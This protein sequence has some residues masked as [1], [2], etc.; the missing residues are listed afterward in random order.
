MF[1]LIQ[2]NK[3]ELLSA[4]LA[5]QI[6]T[7]LAGQSPL[8]SEHILVQSP[9]M[10]TW[11]RLEIA[12]HNGIAAG[13]EFP[14]PS[15]FIWQLC[16]TL[17]LDVPQE[18]AFTKEAMTWKLL[19]LLPTLI[20]QPIYA[21]LARYLHQASSQPELKR[22]QLAARI[23]DI[24]DQYLVYRPDWIADWEAE[25]QPINLSDDQA[26]QPQLWRELV[27]YNHSL[28]LSHYHRA[29]LHQALVD[30]LQDDSKPLPQLPA[31]LFVF[32]IS[33][34]PPQTLSVLHAL[35]HR[36][37]VTVLSLSP[38]QHYWGD[39]VNPKAR[40][41][42]NLTYGEK[43]QLPENWQENLIVGNPLL[44]NNGKLGREL[45]DLM[46]ELP[47]DAIELGD[48]L[49]YPAGDD[50]LL[51]G[52]QQDILDMETRGR[53]LGPDSE[54]YLSLDG[55]RILADD[56]D[57]LLLRSCHSPLREVE[58]LHDH[59]QFMLANNPQLS[60][61]DIVVMLPDVAAYAP[62]IDAVF[63]RR[64]GRFNIPYAIAD[65]GAS[66]ES[67]LINGFL[68][69]LNINRSRF[70]LTEV[71]AILEVPATL[72]RFGLDDEELAL[73][74]Q[75]L[76][77]AGI[78][79][80][81]SGKSRTQQQLPA[82]EQNSW[83]V[84]LKR[85]ILGY[86][87]EDDADLY[88]NH[89]AVAGVEG[90][91]A[92]ALGKLFNFIESLD[93]LS[94]QLNQPVDVA[95][96]IQQL[97]AI[98]DS[99]YSSSDDRD[100]QALMTINAAI[101]KLESELFKAG[102]DEPLDNSI[103]QQWFSS[104]LDESRV[105]QRYLAGSVNF[106]TLMP[107]RS[108]PF[109][110]VCLLGMND[111]LYPRV[112]HPIGF[113]L[114]A[115]QPPRKGDRSRRLD[116]RYLFLEALL[117]ARQQLYISY[118][119]RSQRDN[120]PRNPSM[121]IAE[122]LEYCQLTCMPASLATQFVAEPLTADQL[123]RLEQTLN[124]RLIK[125]QPL[126]PFDAS[127]YQAELLQQHGDLPLTPSFSSQWCPTPIESITAFADGTPLIAEQ[128][129]TQE[130]MAELQ[131]IE[132][133]ALVRF[134]RN[135]AQYFFNRSL[136]L[137]L[138]IALD[139]DDNDEPF[140]PDGL[141]RYQMQLEM[142]NDALAH[143]GV[144]QA[145]VAQKLKASGRLPNAPFDEITLNQYRRDTAPLIERCQFLRGDNQ[146]KLDIDLPF[147]ALKLRLQGHLDNV[148]GKGLV[149]YRPGKANGKDLIRV[150]LRHLAMN[151]SGLQ[152][153][154]YLLDIHDFHA[155][156]P[157]SSEQA[158]VQLSVWLQYFLSGQT[159]PIMLMPKTSLAYVMSDGEHQERLQECR[160]TWEASQIG[161]EGADPHYQR[162]FQYPDDFTEDNFGAIALTLLQPL[163]SLYSKGK[164]EQLGD[165]V[166]NGGMTLQGA[167]Q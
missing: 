41:R 148:A 3:M 150:Y 93:E 53:L 66:Q 132:L 162:C 159:T 112:Q 157:L 13:L 126:Q 100:T 77:K 20:E 111:G 48:D 61:K 99:F 42:I 52:I 12:K 137:D 134:Y 5:D 91:N 78:R 127:L 87:L 44:A 55:R 33:S 163:Q 73:I 109:K 94:V 75:W 82:F 158:H 167:A 67:P 57:S 115:Q 88:A 38:C 101:A 70:A 104:Q 23:A 17:L 155:F 144:M 19:S 83:A 50:K 43:R 140:K 47:A 143:E 116:D 153:H 129:D 51:R 119:G 8:S 121:L 131:I 76:D 135:P 32:G 49:F 65:R 161:G 123:T 59:L 141:Q 69:L 56:D 16:H 139:A 120:S 68:A 37:P 81:R 103:L 147:P 156:S 4:T 7:P 60:A 24:F 133:Q 18:N 105:G 34:I 107:M 114:M 27:A 29:N 113:D 15:S 149:D 6:R 58:T 117:S 160:K 79:W 102:F 45:L 110:V 14:L 145:D 146:A 92:Q 85:L 124:A 151:C 164:L 71:L 84:G 9:G 128:L 21:P 1:K 89:L 154:S 130:T 98:C 72:K 152:R 31:R 46:L 35:G 10:S 64:E 40:A 90:Q 108:I 97:S 36:I 86:A 30:V 166:A 95:P 62:Y 142:I 80:G 54:L 106:C 39:I 26:W 138:S 96:R 25:Q 74:R 125:Q 118:V 28:G 11:L 165:F 122:L 136:K 63:S 22:Y 2:S